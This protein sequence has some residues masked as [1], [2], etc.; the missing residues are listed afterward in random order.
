MQL[1]AAY[2]S[3]LD[4]AQMRERCPHSPL[5]GTGWLEGWRL[6]FGGAELGWKDGPLAT[7]VEEPGDRVYVALY[8]LHAFD[9]ASLEQW[10]GVSSGL[11]RPIRV[12]VATL[13]GDVT[14]RLHVLNGYEGGL[15][16]GLHVRMVAEAAEKAGAPDDYVAKIRHRPSGPVQP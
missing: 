6:T 14:A 1:Y 2:G 4:P 7:V 8:D 12:R 16:S 9:E 10:E 13:D 11:Y 5:V 15:P 3:N